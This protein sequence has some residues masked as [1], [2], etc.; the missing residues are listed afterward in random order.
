M[1]ILNLCW[2]AWT[3]STSTGTVFSRLCNEQRCSYQNNKYEDSDY[4]WF[5]SVLLCWWLDDNEG[6]GFPQVLGS[7]EKSWNF[8]YFIFK[9][10]EVN[11]TS[12]STWKVLEFCLES[13]KIELK[14]QWSRTVQTSIWRALWKNWIYWYISFFRPSLSGVPFLM[15]CLLVEGKCQIL[16]F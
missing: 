2:P 7:P 13:P 9:A 16:V 14:Y 8:I 5:T 6:P 15:F 11:V 3:S 1:P 12:L 10:W 4:H